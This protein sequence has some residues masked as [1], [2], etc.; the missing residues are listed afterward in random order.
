MIKQEFEKMCKQ[1]L[2]G[3]ILVV[4]TLLVINFIKLKLC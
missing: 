1:S 3:I 2:A 4:F